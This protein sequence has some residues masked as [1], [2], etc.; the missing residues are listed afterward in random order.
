[1]SLSESSTAR[2]YNAPPN[3][4]CDSCHADVAAPYRHV[5][6]PLT[7]ATSSDDGAD[8]GDAL[9]A[10]FHTVLRRILEELPGTDSG[11]RLSEALQE[12]LGVE[13]HL[14]AV[15]GAPVPAHRLVDAD[16]AL[17]EIMAATPAATFAGFEGDA[18]HHMSLGD[19]VQRFHGPG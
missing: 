3:S 19:L 6:D 1:M 7:P 17:S 4:P 12:H 5:M 16:I 2:G 13:P 15:V 10:D 9:L 11:R 14:L 8:R 18:R